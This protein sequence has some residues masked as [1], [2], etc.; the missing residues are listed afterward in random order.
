MMRFRTAVRVGA[1][2]AL[3]GAIAV[4]CAEQPEPAG[5]GAPATGALRLALAFR[6][7]VAGI[8]F[9]VED[10]GGVVALSRYVELED[11][12]MPGWL[13]PDPA[14]GEHA[15]ADAFIVLAPGTYMVTIQPMQDPATPSAQCAPASAQVEV[16]D[17]VTSE[18]VLVSQCDTPQNGA[19][20]VV[21]V[22]NHG[23]VI[24]D[25]VFDPGKFI[26]TCETLTLS[27]LG[28]DP[29][30]DDLDWLWEVL[31]APAGAL[32]TLLPAGETA[33]FTTDTIGP[34][35]LRVTATDPFGLSAIL[36]FPVYVLEPAQPCG[37]QVDADCPVGVCDVAT[38]ACVECLD[39]A[40]CPG[41]VCDPAGPACV[42]CLDDA[43][44]PGG[45]CD[46]AGPVCVECLDDADCP[47]ALL[48]G[49]ADACV[50]C[51]DDGDCPGGPCLPGGTCGPPP[52]PVPDC[53]GLPNFCASGIDGGVPWC[54]TWADV[55]HITCA[56]YC[57]GFGRACIEG[58]RDDQIFCNK[59]AVV[60]CFDNAVNQ[61]CRCSG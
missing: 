26:E 53:G 57:A 14:L 39:D 49:P 10:A 42:P 33:T 41:G 19:L 30:G 54:E 3:A 35:T 12:A 44:C 25:F 28:S 11:A 56:N 23:P 59:K 9:E 40:D 7:D 60:G 52:P 50:E 5:A 58:F 21:G 15:F 20:D 6:G 47:A 61:T 45:V 1:V 51:I 37:C 18:I 16:F 13:I 43:D 31:G 2:L 32:Y 22:L 34:Y 46:P 17:G 24:V 27:A 29:D 36:V 8:S 4:G 48:C 38:G 55:G